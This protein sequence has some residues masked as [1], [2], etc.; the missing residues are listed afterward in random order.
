MRIHFFKYQA[1]GNDFVLINN[2][3]GSYK[4]SQD[5]IRSICDRRFGVGADGLML[6]EK[7]PAVNF[8]LRYFNSDGSQSLCGNGSRAAVSLAASLGLVNGHAKFEAFDGIHDAE[9]LEDGNIR[10]RMNDVREVKRM[11]EDYFVNTGSPH[12][13]RFLSDVG[14]HPVFDEGRQIRTSDMFSPGGTNVNFVEK[15]DQNTIFVRTYE[16]GVEDETLSCGT[17]VT[18]AA[19]ASS[20]H[21]L[22]SPVTVKTLG[23]VL[24]VEFSSRHSDLPAGQADTFHDIYLIGPAKLVFEGD[25]EL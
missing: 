24:Q 21:G 17:G 25:L 1:T 5:Q 23:G 6:I 11:N 12:F 8:N 7:H 18:A 2:L 3:S 20:Y 4:F 13:I 15:T 16:R 10:L 14:N 19:L 9:I 22:T